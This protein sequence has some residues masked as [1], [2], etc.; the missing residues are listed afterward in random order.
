MIIYSAG[1]QHS[2][3]YPT[4][5]S[6]GLAQTIADNHSAYKVFVTNI[7]ADYETPN[8]NVSD[9]IYGAHRY[10]NLPDRRSYSM[11]ELFDAMLINKSCIK[12]G[13]TYV[14]FDDE[15]KNVP[16]SLIVDDFES[17][18]QPGKHDGNKVIETILNLYSTNLS[19]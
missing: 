2:S 3:L 15:V 11:E 10:L 19:L 9:Y 16:I 12:A 13:D 6:A 17:H 14:E 4:Y 18:A 8:Y 1:T 5:M 7:G